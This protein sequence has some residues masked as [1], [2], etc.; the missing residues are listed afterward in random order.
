[1]FDYHI[2]YN[3]EYIVWYSKYIFVILF[4]KLLRHLTLFIQC[5]NYTLFR[6]TNVLCSRLVCMYIASLYSLCTDSRL[7]GDDGLTLPDRLIQ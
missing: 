3:V 6:I 1:M 7:D 5:K 4:L 2:I